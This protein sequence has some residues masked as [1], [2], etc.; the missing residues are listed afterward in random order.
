VYF[1]GVPMLDTK[2]IGRGCGGK[3][4]NMDGMIM[5]PMYPM[6]YN[7]NSTCRWDLEVPRPNPIRIMFRGMYHKSY[8]IF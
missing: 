1:T 6:V 4:F 3:M 5:S 8:N 7:K 2:Y